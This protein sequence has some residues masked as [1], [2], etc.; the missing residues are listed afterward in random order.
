M[1]TL[2]VEV[3]KVQK[4]VYSHTLR[5]LGLTGFDVVWIVRTCE[6]A[7]TKVRA[8]YSHHVNWIDRVEDMVYG[9][10]IYSL[11]LLYA[12]SPYVNVIP[13][14]YTESVLRNSYRWPTVGL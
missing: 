2:P 6:L 11:V 4:N 5:A 7:T 12:M 9:D 3:D 8:C 10:R 14:A 13:Y 1:L